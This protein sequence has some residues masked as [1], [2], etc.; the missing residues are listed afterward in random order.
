M[1]LGRFLNEFKIKIAAREEF[2][3]AA[4]RHPISDSSACVLVANYQGQLQSIC[5]VKTLLEEAL[6]NSAEA[7]E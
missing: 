4:L 7:E 1:D 2:V 6:K 5:E 3:L